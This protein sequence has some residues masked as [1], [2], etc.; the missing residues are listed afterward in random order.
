M[1]A[2]PHLYDE[3]PLA[4]PAL[5]PLTILTGNDTEARLRAAESLTEN[6][7][8]AAALEALEGLWPDVHD[9]APLAFRHRLAAAWAEMYCGRLDEASALLSQADGI[10]QSPHFD[11]GDLA[12]HAFTRDQRTLRASL[13]PSRRRCS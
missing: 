4:S 9:D 13:T 7:Q 12:L 8:H 5:P 11:A 6:N 10:A 1:S 2:A 3:S